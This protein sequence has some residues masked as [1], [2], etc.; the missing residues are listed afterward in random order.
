MITRCLACKGPLTDPDT[1]KF[2][3]DCLMISALTGVFASFVLLVFT[4]VIVG[5]VL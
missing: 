3:L 2:N 5:A 1:G 4:V